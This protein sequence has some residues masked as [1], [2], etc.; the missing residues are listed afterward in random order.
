M[1]CVNV[2]VF[3]YCLHTWVYERE[4]FKMEKLKKDVRL[5]RKKEKVTSLLQDLCKVAVVHIHNTPYKHHKCI[6]ISQTSLFSPFTH[7]RCFFFPP[8]FFLLPPSESK[9]ARL[10][11]CTQ[12]T[13]RFINAHNTV[14]T[15]R[16]HK[17]KKIERDLMLTSHQPSAISHSSR[18]S[19]IHPC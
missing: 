4:F 2:I 15:A 9:I 10:S 16:S 5:A 13:P 14:T 6:K 11:L 12:I 19:P 7:P 8:T 3:L 18:S 1:I 17:E